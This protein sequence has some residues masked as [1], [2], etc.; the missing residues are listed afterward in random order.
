MKK[1]KYAVLILTHGRP[2]NV[3]TT[4]T[5]RNAGYT[6]DIYYILDNKDKT[7]AK[8]QA[9][10]GEDSIIVFDKDASKGTFDIMDNQ[11][12]DRAVV[13]ARNEAWNI[14]RRLGLDYFI[15]LDDDYTGLNYRFDKDY[16]YISHLKITNIDK[17]FEAMIT[18]I[19][20]SKLKTICFAQGGDFIG[21]IKSGPFAQAVQT[22]RKAM[23]LFVFK[24]DRPIT[25][26]G[27]INEDVNAYVRHGMV[28]DILL[29][30][31]QV[32]L[33]QVQTQQNE[34][35]LTDI[36]LASGTYVK[37]FYS[38]IANPSSVKLMHMG[39][40]NRRLHHVVKWNSTVP[41]IIDSKHRK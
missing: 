11:D 15:M 22:R 1:P 25:F 5:L 27:R 28:G 40:K 14:A 2:D 17:V 4:P 20:N 18:Y 16:N 37:S 23:N 7:I 19:A 38:V 35:G 36:Y 24:V 8:Y 9:N 21:G 29:T 6:G 39:N 3:V 12:D 26:T 33:E 32:S 13:F 10:F 31:T 34:G 30:T 41:K